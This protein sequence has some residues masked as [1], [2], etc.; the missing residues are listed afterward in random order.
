ML[1]YNDEEELGTIVLMVVQYKEQIASLP[2]H[3][4]THS[5]PCWL[6][7]REDL[8]WIACMTLD[9][10]IEPPVSDEQERTFVDS[11]VMVTDRRN[12]LGW[13]RDWLHYQSSVEEQKAVESKQFMLEKTQDWRQA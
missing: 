4:F 9:V 8:R 11:D 1:R 5:T 6:H 12:G 2:Y 7:C 10:L 3:A 13:T